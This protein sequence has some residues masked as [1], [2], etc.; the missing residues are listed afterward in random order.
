MRKTLYA[1][2]AFST[3][4][5]LPAGASPNNNNDLQQPS[6]QQRRELEN[7]LRDLERQMEELQKQLGDTPRMRSGVFSGP[8]VFGVGPGGRVLMRSSKPKFGFTVRAAPDS[9]ARIFAVTPGSPAEK[10][11][12]KVGDIVTMFNGVRLENVE[13]AGDMVLREGENLDVGDTVS[14]EL[15]RGTEKRTLKMVAADL[16]PNSYAYAWSDSAMKEMEMFPSGGDLPRVVEWATNMGGR[17]MDMEMIELNKDLGEYFGSAEGVLVV[18]APRDSS[19]GLRSGDV[20]LSIDGR[21]PTSPPQ[22]LR[23]LRSYEAGES[24]EVVVLRQK[25][26]VTVTAKV[27]ASQERGFNYRFRTPEPSHFMWPEARDF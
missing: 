7:K 9:G 23:I 27:P 15:R 16:G 26:K 4:L 3:F 13:D 22:A 10:A 20:I 12:L 2:L 25:K 14:V 21:K 24:F 5:A 17:W 1:A 6:A 8:Q 11:G 19:L 18:R